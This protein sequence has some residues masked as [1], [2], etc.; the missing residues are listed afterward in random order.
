MVASYAAGMVVGKG[1]V[2]ESGPVETVKYT[3]KAKE[4]VRM[5]VRTT[6]TSL[7]GN[8][9]A[10]AL[11]FV[12]GT[13]QASGSITD[14]GDSIQASAAPGDHIV[15]YVATHPIPNEIVCIRLGELHFNLIQHN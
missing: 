4:K 15:A 10:F 9:G 1:T 3:V 14:E 13:L 6:E 8:T 2:G 7:C 11:L 5:T 12:N